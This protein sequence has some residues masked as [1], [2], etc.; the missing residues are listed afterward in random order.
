M[1]IGDRVKV[2]A[3]VIVFHHPAHKGEPHNIA[4]M[5]GRIVDILKDWQGRVISPNYP[6]KVE[7]GAR[8]FVHLADTEVELISA[9]V[10]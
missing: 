4:G 7:L 10:G 1:N 5:E 2:S 8:F 9:P 6:I 3:E